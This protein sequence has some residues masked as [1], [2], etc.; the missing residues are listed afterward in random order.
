[1]NPQDTF[2]REPA[3]RL[4]PRAP[5]ARP[6][7]RDIC[8]DDLIDGRFRVTAVIY[9][10][11]IS[12]VFKGEDLENNCREVALKVPEKQFEVNAALFS[13]FQHEE[14]VGARLN[15]PFILRFIPVSGKKSRPYTASEFLRGKTLAEVISAGPLAESE[16]FRL[17]SLVCEALGH[18]HE[19][20]VIHR[21][22]KP[23]NIIVCDDGSIRLIDFGIALVQHGRTQTFVGFEAGTP[24][25]M[26]PERINGRPG[27]PPTD[28]FGLGAILYEMLAGAIPGDNPDPTVITEARVTGD[29]AA[30]RS[31]NP[32]ISP[33]AEEIILKALSRDPRWRHP[34]AAALKADLDAP[35]RVAVTGLCERLRP[36]TRWRRGLRR[37]RRVA[38]WCLVPVAAQA[39]LFL[40]L[41]RHY[42]KK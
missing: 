31:L 10:G 17:G 27:G 28:I 5:E 29:P 4:R 32:R 15:H 19:R 24:Q 42:A 9:R 36:S 16:A 41:W 14:D 25:Y 34:S 8:P 2:E 37:A 11:A 33:Q 38:L 22:L 39:L 6:A 20:G 26:A 12:T 35:D 23:A 7:R 21:D 3:A 1:M 40:F 30:P 13:R 18:M